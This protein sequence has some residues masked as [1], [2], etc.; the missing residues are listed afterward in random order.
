MALMVLSELIIFCEQRLEIAREHVHFKIDL[1]ALRE[2]L[3]IGMFK[4]VIDERNTEA[5]F[6]GFDHS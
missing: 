4:G 1:I 3:Q 2:V 5:A 6:S